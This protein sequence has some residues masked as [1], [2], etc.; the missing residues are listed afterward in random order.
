MNDYNTPGWD[1][2]GVFWTGTVGD[3]EGSFRRC[4]LQSLADSGCEDARAALDPEFATERARSHQLL[5]E[6]SVRTRLARAASR[7]AMLNPPPPGMP[8][9][10][11]GPGVLDTSALDAFLEHLCDFCGSGV[12]A[13][14]CQAWHTAVTGWR[15]GVRTLLLNTVHVCRTRMPDAAVG[16]LVHHC[17]HLERIGLWVGASDSFGRDDTFSVVGLRHLAELRSLVH[18]D[19]RATAHFRTGLGEDA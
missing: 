15:V 3:D 10:P 5:N 17:P 14:V 4:Y 9:A 12:I 18:L 16:A 7:R 2:E 19:L 8:I 11:Q 1:P 13:R 6:A